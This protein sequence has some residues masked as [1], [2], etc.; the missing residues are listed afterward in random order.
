M[1]RKVREKT[2]VCYCTAIH[3]VPLSQALQAKQSRREQNK[4]KKQDGKQKK[5]EKMK[6]GTFNM[7]KKIVF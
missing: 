3:G 6:C 5:K 7:R 2:P 1:G 4:K